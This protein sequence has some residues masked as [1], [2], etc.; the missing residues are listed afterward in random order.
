MTADEVLEILSDVY[1]P[2][3]GI[4]LVDLGLVY[5]VDTRD[6]VLTV[7]MTLT[8]P[9]CAMQDTIKQQLAEVL[10]QPHQVEWTFT[11]RWTQDRISESGREQLLALGYRL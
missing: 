8:S 5:G 4:G 9:M 2:E 6:E 10:P 7:T 1:D 11:P 3:M